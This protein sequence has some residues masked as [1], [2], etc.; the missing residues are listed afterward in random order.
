MKEENYSERPSECTFSGRDF[1][2]E[3]IVSIIMYQD[4]NVILSGGRDGTVCLANRAGN[5][6]LTKIEA[7]ED[8]VETVDFCKE[9]RLFLAGSMT[10][11]IKIYELENLQCRV[12]ISMGSGIVKAIWI[13]IEVVAST[14]EGKLKCYDGR[15]GNGL[16]KWIGH[17]ETILDFDVKHDKI[18][19]GSDDQRILIHPYQFIPQQIS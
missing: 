17:E 10:G 13:G 6:I 7:F 8:S 2:Q 4:N 15:N 11:E 12:T 1:H 14:V 5:R 19:S 9:M 18:I 3:E 16:R